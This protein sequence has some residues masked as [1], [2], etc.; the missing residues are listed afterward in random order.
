MGGDNFKKRLDIPRLVG[1]Y[2]P[3]DTP[4]LSKENRQITM[5]IC[6]TGNVQV[7]VRAF[8]SRALWGGWHHSEHG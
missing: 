6:P 8:V 5:E 1:K 7:G 3:K 4:G 2:N